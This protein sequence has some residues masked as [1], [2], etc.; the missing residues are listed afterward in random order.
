ML[1]ASNPSYPLKVLSVVV[2]I[3]T[4][5]VLSYQGWTYLGVRKRLS[6]SHIPDPHHGSLDLPPEAA[7][8]RT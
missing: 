5:L 1:N 4:P 7:I 6:S 8:P 3:F 2:L